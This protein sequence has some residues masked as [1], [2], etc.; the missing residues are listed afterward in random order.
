LKLQPLMHILNWIITKLQYVIL[1]N[2]DYEIVES[3]ELF[4]TFCCFKVL[5]F[6]FI[7]LDHTKLSQFVAIEIY[8]FVSMYNPALG[9]I[10]L[11]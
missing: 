7:W 5:R 4:D 6:G 10:I 1:K 8:V 3:F 11:H 2:I 9:H